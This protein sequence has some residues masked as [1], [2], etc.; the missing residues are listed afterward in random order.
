[1]VGFDI[2]LRWIFRFYWL[3]SGVFNN[4]FFRLHWLYSFEWRD[5]QGS[6]EGSIQGFALR[7]EKNNEKL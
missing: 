6:K 7:A 5:V 2:M 3:I 4:S 1:M